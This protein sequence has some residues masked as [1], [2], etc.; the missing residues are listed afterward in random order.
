M[1]LSIFSNIIIILF[2][3]V[4]VLVL[5]RRAKLPTILG[6]LFV[7]C[8]VGPHALG[9]I[10]DVKNITQL[11]DFGVMFL[12]FTVALE[13]SYKRLQKMKSQVLSLGSAQVILTTA[14]TTII[15]MW[16]GMT[17]QEAI[18]IGSIVTMSSTAIV[19]KQLVEQLEL[20]TL[21]GRYSVAILLFQDLS[22]IPFFILVYSLAT[23]HQSTLILL[24][25]VI[26]KSFIAILAILVIGRWVM[27][28]LFREVIGSHSLELFTLTALLITLSAAW[29][30]QQMGLS[31][32]LGA[33]LAGM[34]LA[35]TEFRH[36]LEAVIR[37]FRDILIGLFFISIGMLF[38]V[39]AIPSVWKWA[40]LL[41][42][43]LVVFKTVLIF[44][45]SWMVGRNEK[46]AL[47]TGLILA[48]GGEFG[49]ALL[50][51]A[52]AYHLLP[53]LYG[54]VV[55]GA[56]LFSMALAPF[57]IKYN[58]K[59]SEAIFQ[60][61]SFEKK[62]GFKKKF[63]KTLVSRDNHVILCG[64]G[65][66]GQGLARILEKENIPYLAIDLDLKLVQ[67]AKS[68]G[69]PV[70]Y[71]DA[72]LYEILLA[73]GIQNARALV[74]TFEQISATFKILQQV[75]MHNKTIPIFVRAL[76]DSELEKLQNYGATEVIPAS[77]E[78][79]LTL[80]SHLLAAL[81]IPVQHIW[82][83]IN[84]IRKNR[85]QLLHEII[86][87]PENTV[88]DVGDFQKRFITLSENAYAIS[89]TIKEL[90]LDKK[91]VLLASINH[92]GIENF[93][94]SSN[95]ELQVGDT[96]RLYGLQV[97]LEEVEQYLIEGDI[98]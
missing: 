49:F 96:L 94:Y 97:N 25:N 46:E 39:S 24:W 16:L 20:N 89:M 53:P 74:I 27:R 22:A 88:A 37:P 48:Q 29:I 41:L 23:P 36:Q 90:A 83:Q 15:G 72:S 38:D 93:H 9:W 62:E 34:M 64:Y 60:K 42:I 86:L 75:R 59:I 19:F 58:E 71:G 47:C 79:C 67:N 52:L 10:R 12:M 91:R 66:V 54:Q 82:Q 35:E 40:L 50:A 33:F 55:L 76:D 3:V 14:I 43:V 11:A 2:L 80:A 26:A 45:L 98:F 5:F 44:L 8:L 70:I 77:L 21:H 61:I 13:F 30:T 81:E 28:P 63:V 65:R 73:D 7:G 69:Y 4:T 18:I 92:E 31:L 95:T 68:L 56:L 85:Y 6:Y 78:I 84:Q 51:L 1:N 87:D 32:A 17:F 57:I